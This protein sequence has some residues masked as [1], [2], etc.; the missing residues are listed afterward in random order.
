M[1]RSNPI[2][3]LAN[4]GN[5]SYPQDPEWNVY[6]F[7]QN[8]SIRLVVRNFFGTSHPMHMHG[9]NFFVLSEGLGDWDGTTIVNP[10]NPQRRDVQMI[11]PGSPTAPSHLVI[12]INADNPGVWPFHCHIAWHVS[13]GLYVNIIVSLRPSHSMQLLQHFVLLLL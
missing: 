8:T 12:E 2:L 13:A 1:P 10:T 3:L 6:D 7:G 9:H 4:L 11:Q 5:T